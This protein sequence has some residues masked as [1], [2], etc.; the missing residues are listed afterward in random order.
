MGEGGRFEACYLGKINKSYKMEEN[1]I[2]HRILVIICL[3]GLGGLFFASCSSVSKTKTKNEAKAKTEE[4]AKYSENASEN[5]TIQAVSSEKEILKEDL[6]KQSEKQENST[7]TEV[8]LKPSVDPIT[9]E[10]KPSSYQEYEN[11][12]PTKELVLNGDGSVLYKSNSNSVLE[13]QAEEKTKSTEKL[14]DSISKSQKDASK[15]AGSSFE[16]NYSGSSSS[17]QVDKKKSGFQF[18]VY[19]WI[20]LIIVALV[21]IW[22]I[23]RRF[24]ITGKIG[25]LFKT[26]TS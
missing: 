10:K 15:N 1:K 4:R 21:I 16:G 5:S 6:K 12:K 8:L 20:F 14:K 7:S 3:I 24:N 22:Y 18:M 9:G 11:G 25:S 26:K 17:L 19:V 2:K 13:K 23:N